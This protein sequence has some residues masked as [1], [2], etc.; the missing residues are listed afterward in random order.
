[1]KKTGKNLV[2]VPCLKRT[3]LFGGMQYLYTFL[4]HPHYHMFLQ[5]GREENPQ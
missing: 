2:L 3:S 1:M 5:E 4:S